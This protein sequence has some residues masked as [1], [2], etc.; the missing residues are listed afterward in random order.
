MEGKREIGVGGRKVKW[1]KAVGDRGCK[2]KMQGG[3][4]TCGM[5]PKTACPPTTLYLNPE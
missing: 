3:D 4:N 2:G 1:P 5:G